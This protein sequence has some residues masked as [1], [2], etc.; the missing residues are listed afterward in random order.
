MTGED[1]ARMEV[2]T[3]RGTGRG[4]GEHGVRSQRTRGGPGVEVLCAWQQRVAATH[5]DDRARKRVTLRTSQRDVA[6]PAL[7]LCHSTT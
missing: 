7:R 3:G 4:R 1:R 5:T 2:S 6:V